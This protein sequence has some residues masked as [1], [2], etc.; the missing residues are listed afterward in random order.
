M[1]VGIETVEHTLAVFQRNAHS[2]ICHLQSEV[3]FIRS[4]QL[5]GDFSIF[6]RELNGVR[7][8]VHNHLVEILHIDANRQ[9]L[10]TLMQEFH[11]DIPL[12]RCCIEKVVQ[13]L[14]ERHKVN[15]AITELELSLF[16]FSYIHHL[17]DE[18]EDALC[19][20]IDDRIRA[21]ASRVGVVLDEFFQW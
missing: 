12:L 7:Q 21:M 9:F 17:I 11:R 18:S 5:H 8:E 4:F 6:R 15:L 2:V 14:Q 16:D 3:A 20:Q 19:I 13:I 10:N 1:C